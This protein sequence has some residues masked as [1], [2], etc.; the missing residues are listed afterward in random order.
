MVLEFIFTFYFAALAV[1]EAKKSILNAFVLATISATYLKGS[2]T[3]RGSY[4]LVASMIASCFAFLMLLVFAANGEFS[5][6]LLGFAA[7]P[8]FAYRF[9]KIKGSR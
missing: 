5:Y 3:K 4:A 6:S 7:L 1:L 9:R 8:I 2:I